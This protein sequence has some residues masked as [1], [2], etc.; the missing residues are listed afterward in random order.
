MGVLNMDLLILGNGFDL[1]HCLKTRYK[2]FLDYYLQKDKTEKLKNVWLYHFVN[3]QKQ[4]GD[5]WI[6]LEEEIYNV[7]KK[8]DEGIK[9]RGIQLNDYTGTTSRAFFGIIDLY[10]R[11]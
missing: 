10:L 3:K 11:T 8:I 7:I 5:K 9:E 4:L 6:D 2:D 1:A